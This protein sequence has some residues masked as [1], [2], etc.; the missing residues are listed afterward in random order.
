MF[1]FVA[2]T[3]I[4]LAS[5]HTGFAYSEDNA[6]ALAA[7]VDAS[8]LDSFEPQADDATRKADR[9]AIYNKCKRRLTVNSKLNNL[10]TLPC[11]ACC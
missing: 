3:A 4:V 9:L 2:I 11:S 7:A 5:L 6:Q 1:K 8:E 10:P